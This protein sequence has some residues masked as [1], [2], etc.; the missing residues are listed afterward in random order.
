MRKQATPS[1]ELMSTWP[2]SRVRPRTVIAATLLSSFYNLPPY[3][4]IGKTIRSNLFPASLEGNDNIPP[5][6]ASIL[7]I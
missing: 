3:N 7:L 2:P 6:R 4:L 1:S 5:F